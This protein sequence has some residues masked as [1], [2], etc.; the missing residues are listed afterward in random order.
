MCLFQGGAECGAART[1]KKLGQK[2]S[3]RE[4]RRR[5][6]GRVGGKRRTPFLMLASTFPEAKLVYC[7][8]RVSNSVPVTGNGLSEHLV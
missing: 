6:K 8:S 7:L 4:E 2:A 5:R 3:R 1:E